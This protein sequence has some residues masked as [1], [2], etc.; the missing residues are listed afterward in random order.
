MRLIVVALVALAMLAGCGGSEDE[1]A[2]PPATTAETQEPTTTEEEDEQEETRCVSVDRS[3]V[4][5]IATGLTVSGGGTLRDAYAVK[6]DDFQKVY[7]VSAEIDGPG[8][9]GDGDVGTWATNSLEAGGGLILAVD[10]IANEMSDWADGRKTD[11]AFSL[12]DDGVDESRA[13]V[14]N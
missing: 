11:A 14:D 8:I 5:A 4:E 12:S 6:S 9:E 1:D 10:G 7:F 13:C 3:L 2:A